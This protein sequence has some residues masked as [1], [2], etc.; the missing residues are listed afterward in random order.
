MPIEAWAWVL[1][2]LQIACLWSVG[3]GWRSAWLLG[4]AVQPLWIVYAVVTDQIGFIP[5]CTVSGV[6]QL[7][8]WLRNA[9]PPTSP[10]SARQPRDMGKTPD[11]GVRGAFVRWS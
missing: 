8:T 7:R 4:A 6:V 9:P 5:G 10:G 11:G 2:T 1:T 3:R